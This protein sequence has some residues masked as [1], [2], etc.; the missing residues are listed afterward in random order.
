MAHQLNGEVCG[1]SSEGAQEFLKDISQDPFL[2]AEQESHFYAFGRFRLKTAERVL[3][4]EGELVPLTPKVFDILL[5]LVE[6]GGQVVE[7]DDLMKRVWPSTFVEEGNLTQNVSLLRKALG[8]SPSGP[9]FIETVPRR[10]YRFVA[11]ISETSEAH[12][13]SSPATK[14]FDNSPG[15][16][17][18]SATLSDTANSVQ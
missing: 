16:L 14:T 7:K 4:R 17:L 13:S 8:E 18:A 11:S 12:E 15:R 1:T 10:G 5:T 9:Q 2:M 3:L 6:K